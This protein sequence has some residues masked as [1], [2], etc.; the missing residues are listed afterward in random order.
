M[1]V[2]CSHLTTHSVSICCVLVIYCF[3]YLENEI[4][5][6]AASLLRMEDLEKIYAEG[7]TSIEGV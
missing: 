3:A 1:W 2:N 6:E 4:D 7:G 5:D